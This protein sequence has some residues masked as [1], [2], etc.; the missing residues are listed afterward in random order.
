MTMTPNKTGSVP[1]KWPSFSVGLFVIL[2]ALCGCT[3]LELADKNT[4]SILLKQPE[5][6]SI[7]VGIITP[8][9]ITFPSGVYDPDFQ[10][11]EGIYYRSQKTLIQ[12]ALGINEV[13]HGGLFLPKPSAS[14][15]RQGYW[16]DAI[17]SESLATWGTRTTARVH[18]FD[19]PIEYE[20]IPLQQP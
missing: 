3:H 10:T 12:R 9:T 7:I 8:G 5:T 13:I 18:R 20:L 17:A 16:E 1:Q 19:K 15:N 14:D 6:R 2:L 11:Q 4:Q